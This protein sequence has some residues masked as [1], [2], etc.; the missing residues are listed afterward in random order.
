MTKISLQEDKLLA[1]IMEDADLMFV[2]WMIGIGLCRSGRDF[3]RH[4]GKSFPARNHIGKLVDSGL[5]VRRGRGLVLSA[6]AAAVFPQSPKVPTGDL[7]LPNSSL[8]RQPP[9][10]PAA[11]STDTIRSGNDSEHYTR[12]LQSVEQ[13]A[14]S[15]EGLLLISDLGLQLGEYGYTDEAV[16]VLER[17]LLAAR[18]VGDL[19]IQANMLNNLGIQLSVLGRT[20]EAI[21]SF[22]QALLIRRALHDHLGESRVL[23]NLADARF[24][25]GEIR[26]A[27]R[28]YGQALSIAQKIGNSVTEGK[29]LYNLGGVERLIG[30]IVAARE[31]WKEALMAF[32]QAGVNDLVE[33][34]RKDLR[35]LRRF[36]WQ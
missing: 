6:P 17:A 8:Y 29:I 25:Q 28:T 34:V 21:T 32:E 20:E 27:I 22:E 12:L 18:E 16:Q 2:F 35:A 10:T 9:N 3:D 33:L 13:D 11:G 5:I 19:A 30:H 23:N 24:R 26:L 1:Q 4:F 15:Y 31:R 36:P 7:N 14:S